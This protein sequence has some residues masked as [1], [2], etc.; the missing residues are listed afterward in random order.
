MM[1]KTMDKLVERLTLDHIPPPRERK[2]PQVRNPNF[3]RA[4]VPQIIQRAQGNHGDQLNRS[5]FQD[6]YVEDF[7]EEPKYQNHLLDEDDSKIYLTKE[8]HGM[9]QQEQDNELLID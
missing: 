5:P 8:E 7:V 4:P 3:K 2:E 9:F 6:N 1:V